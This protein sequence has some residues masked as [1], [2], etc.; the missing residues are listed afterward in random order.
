MAL[1]GKR[2][3][4]LV[5]SSNSTVE[6]EFYRALPQDVSLHVAR[7]PITQVNPESIA[8]M[9]DP[10]ETE[11][12]KLASADV[13]V[14]VIR[15]RAQPKLLELDGMLVLLGLALLLRLLVLGTTVIQEFADGWHRVGRDL[16]QVEVFLPCH[17][18]RLDCRHDAQ[19]RPIF[20]DESDFRNSNRAID[21]RTGRRPLWHVAGLDAKGPPLVS[22]LLL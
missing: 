1:A 11:S 7:L 19:L 14:M 3:G 18:Q 17:L 2:I 15:A 16:H 22:Y 8:G 13:D 5:P 9:V 20:I 12:K 21:A 6:V 10:L 4:L